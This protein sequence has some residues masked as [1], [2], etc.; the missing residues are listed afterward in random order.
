MTDPTPTTSRVPPTGPIPTPPNAPE[1]APKRARDNSPQNPTKPAGGD[2]TRETKHPT[3]DRRPD[4]HKIDPSRPVLGGS[5]SLPPA[6]TPST[7]PTKAHGASGQPVP[8]KNQDEHCDTKK[9][10]PQDDRRGD[11]KKQ[12]C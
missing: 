7:A 2:T 6:T 3:D 11:A 9:S 8:P 12:G 5:V 1:G 4:D 10:S